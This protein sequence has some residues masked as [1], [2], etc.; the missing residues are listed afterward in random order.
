MKL[1]SVWM[2]HPSIQLNQTF[3]YMCGDFDVQRG[4]RVLVP[5]GNQQ[6]VA[7]VDH[8]EETDLDQHTYEI[9]NQIHLKMIIKMI[10]KEPI[11]NEELMELGKW[12]ADQTISNVIQC[13]Q[14]MLPNQLKPKSTSGSIK[15]EVFAHY[16]KECE[17]LTI[18]QKELLDV[19][20]HQDCLRK[21]M[22]AKSVSITKKLIAL[23][24]IEWVE[25][26]VEFVGE[27]VHDLEKPLSLTSHQQLAFQQIQ[28][29][30]QDSICLLHGT[31]GSGKTE[32]YL[33]LTQQYVQQKQQVLILVPEIS[34]TPQMVK[35]VVRR[36]GN[37][38]AIYHSN[39]S[40]QEK[41]EQYQRVRKQE[42]SIVVGTR[43]AVFMPF[44][45]LGLIVLDEEHDGSYKQD[46]A[47][48]Y[49]CRDVAIHRAK[50]HQ[51][52]VILGSATPSLESYARAIKNV[53]HLV[54]L[55]SRVFGDLAKSQIVDMSQEIRRGN[56]ILSS[57]LQQKL[58]RV[59]QQKKQAILLLNRR[60]YTPILRCSNCGHVMKCPHCDV[61]LSYHKDDHRL[62]CHICGESYLADP[63]CPSCGQ[64][65]WRFLGVGTQRLQ[66]EVQRL[67][68]Q[69]R[70]LRLDADTSMKKGAH[71]RILSAFERQEAD[72]LVGTQMISKGL[73]YP[74]VTL[75][76]VL[77]ADALLN[78]SDYRCVEMTFDLLVQ[79][80]GRSG[81]GNAEG[82]V[83]LQAY[84][85]NHYGIQTAAKQDYLSFF[86]QEMQYRHFGQYPP[87]TYLISLV[88][89]A[90]DKVKGYQQAQEMKEW[91]V[92][93]QVQVLGPSELL[94]RQDLE[95][96]RI[97]L[98]GKDLEKMK[99][100]V[101]L[102]N[103]KRN[104]K[105]IVSID[106]NPLYLD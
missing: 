28:S 14:A 66:E 75:V 98:R 3:T 102:W 100:L 72:I 42:V 87:Y 13:Y 68:P 5:F 49:H 101:R 23:G 64:K 92:Q 69:A 1:A 41:Y 44:V 93:Q 31:T 83:V 73:D 65:Q 60:G 91:F 35:R 51:A 11:L 74:N 88:V 25:K 43:S 39:L 2:E 48:R 94:K 79:A 62:K 6:V 17:S 18:K 77:Q 103:Q 52:K 4:M 89:S 46:S 85:A 45:H 104:H 58:T 57:V 105:W 50:Y 63:V 95:R 81:R 33:Q 82:E 40:A 12:M 32:L 84:D 8:V 67:F 29:L 56:D 47:P 38:V 99:Q 36:F 37:Q 54:T 21:D 61:A 22:Y 86:H 24:C 106:V 76:G 15:K 78:R 70:V 71:E 9:E 80:S 59:L 19:C 90:K 34:L 20:K 16:V 55:D 96:Y 27:H 26:E 53:Y 10:D 97:L 30:P 7:F